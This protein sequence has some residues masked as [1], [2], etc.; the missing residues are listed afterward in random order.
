MA[1]RRKDSKG[2]VLK[3][4]ETQRPDGTYSYRWRTADGKRHAVYGRTLEE[5]R[6]KE[7]AVIKDKSDGIRTDAKSARRRHTEKRPYRN[8]NAF[9]FWS[10]DAF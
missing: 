7:L 9:H 2:R 8:R 5:L 4:N 6:E 1:E 3:E 10:S